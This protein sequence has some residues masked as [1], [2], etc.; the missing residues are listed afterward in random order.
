[1]GGP[2]SDSEP[3]A[4]VR[5][6]AEVIPW[7]PF[8]K[9]ARFYDIAPLLARPDLMQ[10]VVDEFKA[11][12]GTRG[13]THVAGI[14]SRGFLFTP[15]AMA[16]GVP[17]VMLRKPGKI[18][19]TVSSAGYQVEY[20]KRDGLCIQRDAVGAGDKVL[21]IDDLVATGGTLSSG[22]QC[23]QMLGAE[24]VECACV[25]S[26]KLFEDPPA[27]SGIPSRA[28]LWKDL[29]LKVPVWGLISEDLLTLEAKLGEGYVDDGEE[30]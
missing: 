21:L 25:V 11:R 15:I 13:V 2:S 5:A 4:A 28:R 30:H 6:I 10:K 12:Y 24:V 27:D 7:Y 14:E 18:P 1:M 17:F 26:L 19:N 23:V 9:I 22:I 3:S 20:G 8:K 16:L 29:G